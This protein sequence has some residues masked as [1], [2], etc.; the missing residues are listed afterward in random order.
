MTLEKLALGILTC[1]AAQ[2]AQATCDATAQHNSKPYT[3]AATRVTNLAEYKSWHKH[4]AATQGVKAGFGA[5]VDKQTLLRGRC[6]WEVTAYEDHP[7]HMVRWRTFLVAVEGKSILVEDTS[8]GD[9]MTLAQWRSN[10][11]RTPHPVSY[12]SDSA[13]IAALATW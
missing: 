5:H 4:A 10:R 11:T 9:P 8:G 12:L 2:I 1:V 3:T 6:F 7:T 13:S